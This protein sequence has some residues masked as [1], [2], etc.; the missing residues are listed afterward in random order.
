MRDR[1]GR[2]RG[3]TA[4][5]ALAVLAYLL[6]VWGAWL[7]CGW[8]GAPRSGLAGQLLTWGLASVVTSTPVERFLGAQDR[9]GRLAW[10]RIV[11][12]AVF[13]A[14]AVV[15]TGLGF[16]F[17]VA[18]CLLAG[19][20]FLT[21]PTRSALA[22]AL[23]TTVAGTAAVQLA[24]HAGV[25]VHVMD[26]RTAD[27]SAL[28]L[29]LIGA[30]GL[31]NSWVLARRLR[32]TADQLAAE[33]ARRHAELQHA[34]THD[35]LTGLLG[36]RGLEGPLAGAVARARP[37]CGAGLVFLDLDGFKLVN[38]A[39]G[40][41]AG[42]R[43]LQEVSRRLRDV[44]AG[45]GRLARVGGDEFVVLVEA[46]SA[47]QVQ[48]LAA[49]LVGTLDE[50]VLVDGVTMPVGVSVGTAHVDHPATTDDLVRAADASMYEHKRR[51]R[52]EVGS[53]ADRRQAQT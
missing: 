53:R 26:P 29:G 33:Q 27:V 47:E 46:V 42:D 4:R 49:D 7:A 1:D 9:S 5:A 18:A 25:G 6:G 36:R 52:G 15:P 40:H 30:V 17:P 11:L 20:T 31:A 32:V 21:A 51:R 19:R 13:I 37:G 28:S 12:P 14:A 48:A 38:D 44:V 16:L 45:R 23:A 35:Q 3:E 2:R 10:L 50:P 34:A 8:L 43:V 39:Y 24:A 41:E 22:A